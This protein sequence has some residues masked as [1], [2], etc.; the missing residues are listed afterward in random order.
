MQNTMQTRLCNLEANHSNE[1]HSE[2][3]TDSEVLPHG[4]RHGQESLSHHRSM[5]SVGAFRWCSLMPPL[6]TWC[7]LCVTH[8]T[9]RQRHEGQT[10][11]SGYLSPDSC[12][13]NLSFNCA[14]QMKGPGSH[15]LMRVDVPKP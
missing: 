9:R 5:T 13:L 12:F 6:F 14:G 15:L 1:T 10:G 3:A 4:L 11:Q 2:L 8:R 7:M